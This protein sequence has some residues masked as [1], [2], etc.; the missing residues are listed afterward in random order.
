MYGNIYNHGASQDSC[1]FGYVRQSVLSAEDREMR[2]IAQ[3]WIQSSHSHRDQMSTHTYAHTGQVRNLE[4]TSARACVGLK[5]MLVF[6]V[7][8]KTTLS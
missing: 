1:H 2:M 3:E 4:R 6:V 8:C 7:T 5:Q